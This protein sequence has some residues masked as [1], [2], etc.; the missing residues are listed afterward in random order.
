[1]TIP[2][3][4]ALRQDY[5]QGRLTE[6]NVDPDPIRQF[7]RWFEQAL[8][9]KLPEPNAMTLAT[10]NAQGQPSARAVLLKDFDATGFVFYTHY[11]SAKA[12]HL[13]AN[14]RVAL[15]FVWLELERQV[16]IEGCAAQVAPAESAAYFQSR[17]RASQLSAWASRQSQV[18]ASRAVL[19][20]RLQALERHYGE[21]CTI[22]VPPDWGGY[23]VKPTL[24]EFWQGRPGRLHDRLRYR[25][26]GEGDWQLERLEP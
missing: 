25:Q 15:L 8:N 7:Q 26:Q 23:R 4:A 12:E 1:M 20:Q 5:T 24:L 11:H 2:S 13:A 21:A 6:T 17:P 16:R 3:L 18:V 22:P 10:V 19:E 9:A 14:P